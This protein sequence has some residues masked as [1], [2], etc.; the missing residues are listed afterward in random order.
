MLFVALTQSRIAD[1]LQ[2]YSPRQFSIAPDC[3]LTWITDGFMS[4]LEVA[5]NEIT[6]TESLLASCE[7][8]RNDVIFFSA[9]FLLLDR[10]LRI[11]KSTSAGRPVYYTQDAHGNFFVS[12]HVAL[13]RQAGVTIEEDPQSLP[14]L[15]IYR[16]VAPPRSFYRGIRRM[17]IAGELDIRWKSGRWTLSGEDS[18]YRQPPPGPRLSEAQAVDT[19][20]G[21]LIDSV[22]ALK[23]VSSQVTTLLSGGLDSSLLSAVARDQIGAHDTFSSSYPF[24][25]PEVNFEQKYALSAAAALSTRHTL[26]T[27][28]GSDFVAGVVDAVADAEAP[29]H[30]LQSTL[31]HLLFRHA[32]PKNFNK[33]IIGEA[34]DCA[35]GIDDHF[36]VRRALELPQRISSFGP[37]Y[38][39][40]KMLGRKW[41]RVQARTQRIA[42]MKNSRLPI[43][44]PLNPMWDCGAYG[45]F[46]WVESNY[47]ASREEIVAIRHRSLH[48]FEKQRFE[49]VLSLYLLNYSEVVGTTS[50]WSKLAEGQGKTA[51]YPFVRRELLDAAF[52]T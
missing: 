43:A 48:A 5:E 50:I 10:W 49:D 33:V 6:A 19:V 32:I 12:T 11:S 8:R 42:R 15:L 36:M 41:K 35:F 14:E 37:V 47:G 21:V 18:G 34:A 23:P 16:T 45:D 20:A 7:D 27:P 51:Y 40:L 38:G 24:D 25:E 22:R 29:L 30:H 2:A 13:L 3:F 52:S 44:H 26:F 39:G 9:R 46:A 17:K 4:R 1:R 31:L 28:H